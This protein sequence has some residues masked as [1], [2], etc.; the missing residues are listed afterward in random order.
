MGL[1]VEWCV[2]ETSSCTIVFQVFIPAKLALKE[3]DFNLSLFFSQAEAR[4]WSK[5]AIRSC[6][7]SNPTE[8][9]TRPSLMPVASLTSGDNCKLHMEAG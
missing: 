2:C 5:S 3:R 7:S 4:A 1:A 6:S 8:I 9:L